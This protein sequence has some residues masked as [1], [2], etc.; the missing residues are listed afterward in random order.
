MSQSGGQHANELRD[1][2]CGARPIPDTF[3]DLLR[4]FHAD[5]AKAFVMSCVSRLVNDGRAVCILL[6]NG[7]VELRLPSG[8]VFILGDTSV[9]RIA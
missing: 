7:D 4:Q 9:T 2:V 8:E 3:A 6:G 1:R 5:P